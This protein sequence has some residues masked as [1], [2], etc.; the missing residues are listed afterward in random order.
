MAFANPDS[1]R[2]SHL[3]KL[4]IFKFAKRRNKSSFIES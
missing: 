3:I 1:I 4:V 2:L